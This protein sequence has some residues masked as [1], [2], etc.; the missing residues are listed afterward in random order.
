MGLEDQRGAT[1][2][3]WPVQQMTAGSADPSPVGTQLLG[4]STLPLI[5][6]RGA[7]AEALSAQRGNCGQ[8]RA[9]GVPRSHRRLQAA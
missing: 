5:P 8:V 6:S 3:T 1:S 2:I 7:P 9:L 4:W